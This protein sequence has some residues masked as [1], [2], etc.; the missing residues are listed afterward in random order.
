M[1][2]FGDETSVPL[3]LFFFF[4]KC[5]VCTER[6]T[7]SGLCIFSFTMIK[8]SHRRE[9]SY[10]LPIN[11]EVPAYGCFIPVLWF[12]VGDVSFSEP[13]AVGKGPSLSLKLLL[14]SE[15]SGPKEEYHVCSQDDGYSETDSR[16][17]RWLHWREKSHLESGSRGKIPGKLWFSP[18]VDNQVT[19]ADMYATN[20]ASFD[21]ISTNGLGQGLSRDFI[22]INNICKSCQKINNYWHPW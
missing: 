1:L 9:L 13:W 5:H 4:K 17:P 6:P 20:P 15:G 22:K 10:D 3:I 14:K 21:F 2:N 11:P 8:R 12:S 16:L 7:F 18:A 19:H